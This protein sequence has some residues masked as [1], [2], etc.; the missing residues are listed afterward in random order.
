MVRATVSDCKWWPC[1]RIAWPSSIANQN[2]G[3]HGFR[4]QIVAQAYKRR[5][6]ATSH[7]RQKYTFKKRLLVR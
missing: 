5:D 7:I 3:E 1:I 4:S 2:C 6:K